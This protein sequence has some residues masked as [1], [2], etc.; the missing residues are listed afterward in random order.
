VQE[1]QPG[2]LL[3]HYK[4]IR[5]L[6][7]GGM[8]VVW[9][10]A[11]QKLGRH[12][13]VKLLLEASPANSLALERFW[14]EARTASSLNHPGICT[15]YEINE[16]ADSPFIVM[17]LLEGSSLE[18]LYYHHAMPYPRLLEL[19][20]QLADA[21]DA[22]HQRGILHRDIKPGNIFLANSGQAKLLDFGLA[23]FSEAIEAGQAT[24]AT[25]MGD[26]TRGPITVSGSSVGTVA[27]MSPEQARGEDLDARSDIFS[28]GSVLYEMATGAH[29]FSGT[30]T[31]IIF[32]RILNQPPTAP[33]ALNS[34]LPAGFQS[35]LDK[36]LEKD[37]ELRCQSA[38]ELRADLKRLQRASTAGIPA[39]ASLTNA[40]ASTSVPA[41]PSTSGP[42]SGWASSPAANLS[43]PVAPPAGT[44]RSRM[45]T[46]AILLVV[47]AAGGAAAW[48][49]WP[50]SR[51]FAS[52][53][54]NQITNIGTVERIALSADGRFLAE[55]KN[56]NGQRTLWIRNTVTNTDTQ[57]LG[58]I[59]TEYVG[60]T[61]S[62]DS[63]YLYFTRGTPAN[64]SIRAIY[65]M[66]VFGGT[67]RQ[68][69][70]DAD[71]SISFAP[72]GSRFTY[73]R[74]TPEQKDHY[75]EVHVADRDGA[76]NQ[77]IYTYPDVIDPPAWSPDGKRIAWVTTLGSLKMALAVMDLATKK[78]T[79]LPAALRIFLSPNP[80]GYTNLA[81]LPD[82]RHLL[83]I[84]FKAH[85]DRA[86]I[87]IFTIPSGEFHS[88]TNDVNAYGQLA[89]SADGRSLATV[90]T[91]VDSSIAYLK[92]DGGP[93]L[94]VTPLRITPTSIAWAG[95][96]RI[97]YIVRHNSIGTID[98]TSG[99]VHDFDVGDIE[100]GSFVATCG[101]G[102]ILFTG[103]PKDGG[104]T[105]LFKMNAAGEEITQLTTTGVARAPF[106]SPDSQQVYYSVRGGNQVSLWSIPMAGGTPKQLLPPGTYYSA[107][108]S[109]DFKLAETPLIVDQLKTVAVVT[110]LAT[111]HT[112]PPLPTDGS[113]G[114]IYI[115]FAADDKAL[116][117][118]VDRNGGTT[119]LYQ[120]TDGSATHLMFDPGPESLRDFAWSPSGKQLALTRLK[121]SSDVVFITDQSGK[122]D[123]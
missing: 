121:S 19:G 49:F 76:N 58:P 15:I 21:L 71:S 27:Y 44:A 88:V 110:D 6:G 10:A 66:P 36:V 30:T 32:D 17:E 99:D 45:L 42:N 64:S 70:Y 34:L 122:A 111:G 103:I 108:I 33:M 48:R 40:M 61:F 39:A 51:P 92:P 63:N 7:Q 4:L 16:S 78:V 22:A 112:L 77:V 52:I 69:I 53:A 106:C 37:R 55:V 116:V 14:R 60:L 120:P 96:D 93:P 97:V 5:L 118:G 62:P 68:I 73:V 13:A 50:R 11:D 43:G 119:L 8:G 56:D 20:I 89:L 74:W 98:R 75:S 41:Q 59:A 1:L 72:D 104:E 86:Q 100:L 109:H 84:Y 9:E 54:V 113:A 29:P 47:L 102:H 105:R 94:S 23:K 26:E 35:L 87:G 12:V 18:K 38:A 24:A 115:H 31:A 80:D 81:W 101:D 90:L 95:E 25:G 117:Y 82:N 91:D 79:T 67:P 28:L 57:I 114:A 123:R 2:T 46:A 65:S 107:E 85:T 3:G 83:V